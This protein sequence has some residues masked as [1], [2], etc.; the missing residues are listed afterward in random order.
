VA[1]P[2]TPVPTTVPVTPGGVVR[3]PE[4]VQAENYLVGGEG[5][6]YHDTTT[7]NLGGAYRNDGVDIAYAPSLGSWVV[8]QIRAGEWLDY[9]VDAPEERNYAL[10]F[11]LSSP[12]GGQFVDL[13]VDGRSEVT[14]IAPR[15]ESYDA[16]TTISTQLRLTR[17][18][19]RIRIQFYGDG[20][21]L[22]AFELA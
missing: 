9:S 4:T 2:T 13:Q 17:G 10:R 20:Q 16:Y 6:A 18:I 14:V 1:T 19:H 12:S 11:R 7:G 21:N 15:T 8:T 22:D 5:I 3:L